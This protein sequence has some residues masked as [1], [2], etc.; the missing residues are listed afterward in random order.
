MY[1]SIRIYRSVRLTEWAAPTV[2]LGS[3]E[4]NLTIICACLPVV[5][6]LIASMGEK[7]RSAF[8][9][10]DNTFRG[11][12][13]TFFIYGSRKHSHDTVKLGH[14][15]VQDNSP[16]TDESRLR[17]QHDRLYP[18]SATDVNGS[19]NDY[20]VCTSEERTY[21]MDRLEEMIESNN[22]NEMRKNS[23]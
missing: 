12:L 19:L 17:K 3:A 9:S 5:Q 13:S 22:N 6:P 23:S 10:S 16:A 14:L 4:T 8:R 7:L 18:I 2:L 21:E 1:S 20:T 15:T 11:L